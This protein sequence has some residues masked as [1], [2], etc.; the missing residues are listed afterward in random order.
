MEVVD[1]LHLQNQED[2]RVVSVNISREQEQQLLTYALN[3]LLT[4]GILSIVTTVNE[5]KTDLATIEIKEQ[6]N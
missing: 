5:D 2:G 3:D 1:V 4:K 6:P